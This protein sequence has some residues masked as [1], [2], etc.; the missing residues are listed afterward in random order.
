M[1]QMSSQVAAKRVQGWSVITRV[2]ANRLPAASVGELGFPSGGQNVVPLD[3]EPLFGY[4]VRQD[5]MRMSCNRWLGT[6]RI[7][8]IGKQRTSP[9]KAARDGL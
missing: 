7:N 4:V 2:N 8:R 9:Q 1:N 3:F 6:S 5:V